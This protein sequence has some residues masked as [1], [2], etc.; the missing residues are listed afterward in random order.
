MARR[1][2]LGIG[3]A[4]AALGIGGVVF[5]GCAAAAVN[6]SASGAFAL[7]SGVFDGQSRGASGI[8]RGSTG[9]RDYGMMRGFAAGGVG[10]GGVSA[11][12][13]TR[14]GN[15]VPSGASVD[16]SRNRIV[17][18][19]PSVQ[20]DV[21]GSPTGQK[22]ETFRIAGLVNPTVVVPAG[23]VVHVLFL[24]ADPDMMHNFVV[25]AAKPPFADVPMMQGAPAFAGAAMPFLSAFSGVAAQSLSTSFVASAEGAY[26]YL[27]TV[28][29]H[30]A[31]GMY[32]QFIVQ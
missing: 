25:T 20:L 1:P 2:F 24:N 21:I 23:A 28:P 6:G 3:L 15:D 31:D 14:L 30:A 32:G 22:D 12:A 16:R 17:F 19:S 11:V 5:G 10:T 7:M 9:S 27:C 13:V 18:S 8:M 4:I 26:T 29:G